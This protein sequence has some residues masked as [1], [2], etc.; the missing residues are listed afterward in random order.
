MG[1]VSNPSQSH[2][3]S[4]TNGTVTD[5]GSVK[6]HISRSKPLLG[7]YVSLLLFMIIYC[8]RPEDWIPGLSSV[9]LA[10]IA[11]IIAL[12]ALIFSLGDIRRRLPRE[13]LFL[14]LLIGQLFLAAAMSSVWRGGA[15]RTT[16]DFAKI[17]IIVW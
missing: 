11:G 12:L 6:A 16:L 5:P 17:L 10:K 14:A 4:V 15:V 7:A 13:V 1:T 2:A 9:P 8:A 3:S